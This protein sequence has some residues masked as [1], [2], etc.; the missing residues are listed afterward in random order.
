MSYLLRDKKKNTS[1]EVIRIVSIVLVL[2]LVY[3]FFSKPITTGLHSIQ[4]GVGYVFGYY[5]DTVRP[6][7]ENTL[8]QSLKDENEQLKEIV[9][10]KTEHDDRLL[11]VIL[12]RPPRIPYDSLIVDIGEDHDLSEGNLVYAEMDYIIGH[13]EV[14]NSNSSVVKLFSAPGEKIDVL[15]GSSTIP[16]VAEG[17]GA[18]NFYIKVPKNIP[19]AEGDQILVPGIRPIILGTA[20]HVDSSEGEA[21]SH[22]YFKLP[23]KL[24]ALHYVQIKKN[25]H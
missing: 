5:D 23:V 11:S 17:R 24:N 19:I 21:F 9:G 15:V 18:G 3:I 22:I 4:R 2:V 20:E 1:K 7:S 8:I 14:V 13:I 25:A 10:R 6:I 12:S 16:V